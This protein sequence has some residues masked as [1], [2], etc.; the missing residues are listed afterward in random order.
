MRRSSKFIERNY[1]RKFST[2]VVY[3]PAVPLHSEDTVIV[4]EPLEIRMIC[5]KDNDVYESIPLYT[6]MRT[7]GDDEELIIGLLFSEGVIKSLQDVEHIS[8]CENVEED[9]MGNVVNVFLKREVSIRDL[10]SLLRV[11]YINS[12]CGLCG[13][14]AIE[15]L[16]R[17]LVND[18]REDF[19]I[20]ND[21]YFYH[22]PEV[23]KEHQG[24]FSL[25]GGTHACAVFDEKGNLLGVKEDVGRHNA[26]DKLIGYMLRSN[27]IPLKRT[28]L[29]VSGRASYE[30]VYKALTA[31]VPV[32]AS[33]GAP[34]SLAVELA[35]EFGMTLIGFLSKKRFVVYNDIG[36]LAIQ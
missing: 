13:K 17:I 15:Y 34:S 26:M 33:I 23:L 29:L 11:S 22:L 8:Y 2:L 19:F 16:K 3:K 24:K 7:P 32:F 30:L 25:T 35:K 10:S 18:V 4:E 27:R 21:E 28:C 36:R 5:S 12:A 6:T 1:Y 9:R 31:G 14:L 20:L